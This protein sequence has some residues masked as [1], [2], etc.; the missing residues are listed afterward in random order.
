MIAFLI[1]ILV[2]WLVCRWLFRSIPMVEI[3]PP[4]PSTIVIQIKID[5]VHLNGRIAP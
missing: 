2:M 1:S 3:A 5:T 4:P